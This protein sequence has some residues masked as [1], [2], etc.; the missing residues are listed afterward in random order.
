[1]QPP[2][3]GGND[4]GRFITT[5]N[6]EFTC[7]RYN[8][9]GDEIFCKLSLELTAKKKSIKNEIVGGRRSVKEGKRRRGERLEGWKVTKGARERNPEAKKETKKLGVSS[10]E[11]KGT[12]TQK[13]KDRS[14]AVEEIWKQRPKLENLCKVRNHLDR[15]SS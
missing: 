3:Y 6:S 8:G 4:L 14:S 2:H 12:Q 11:N 13:L 9:G 7:Q 5:Y 10:K 15:F 1:M